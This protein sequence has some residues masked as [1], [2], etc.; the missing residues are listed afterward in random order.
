MAGLMAIDVY[1]NPPENVASALREDYDK[2]NTDW[3]RL[4][5]MGISMSGAS[6]PAKQVQAEKVAAPNLTRPE[7]APIVETDPSVV[8]D[9]S[10][11]FCR[12]YAPKK[13]EDAAGNPTCPPV[14]A[15][16]GSEM[17]GD[18]LRDLAV[19]L[20]VRTE[21][22]LRHRKVTGELDNGKSIARTHFFL[23]YD[24][25]VGWEDAVA[26]KAGKGPKI[27]TTPSKI[28]PGFFESIGNTIGDVKDWAEGV[29]ETIDD[30]FDVDFLPSDDA[31]P[32]D[33]Q[34]QIAAMGLGNS[35]T[36][37]Q[38]GGQ[39]KVPALGA[40]QRAFEYLTNSEI[41]ARYSAT[42]SL[43]YDE[44]GDWGANVTQAMG[45]VGAQYE[46][47]AAAVDSA[48]ST[49]EQRGNRLNITGHSLGGGLAQAAAMYC[50]KTYPHIRLK[51]VHFN[52]AGLHETTA[53]DVSGALLSDAQNFP[54]FAQNVAGELLT[55]VQTPGTFPLV[56]NIFNW[57]GQKIP[58]ALGISDKRRAI[59]PGPF[60]VGADHTHNFMAPEPP[61]P[62]ARY[63]AADVPDGDLLPLILPIDSQ[64]RFTSPNFEYVYEPFSPP[65]VGG[66]TGSGA[67]PLQTPLLPRG[68]ENSSLDEISDVGALSN[69]NTDVL[70]PP[71]A[72]MRYLR[73]TE[74]IPEKF[75]H[76][77]AILGLADASADFDSFVGQL[78]SYL[79]QQAG[80]RID[81]EYEDASA[82]AR[83]S[84][85]AMLTKIV[86]ALKDLSDDIADEAMKSLELIMLCL[87]Y[88]PMDIGGSTFL[89]PPED[90]S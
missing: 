47:V 62:N 29:V 40:A 65:D 76:I 31:L 4:W 55:S 23:P 54:M 15:F 12:F 2:I 60:P 63:T 24:L 52:A 38:S 50:H 82:L 61:Y 27:E 41:W 51:C 7:G 21:F 44:G 35:Q 79:I 5:E 37:L 33:I 28:K 14:L 88:H 18:E 66:Y 39:S 57:Q 43:F 75:Q 6:P 83:L 48:I 45:S 25:D 53:K 16:R 22:V 84:N 13:A 81:K 69:G 49:A 85:V 46:E 87:S 30:H 80:E 34:E 68:L 77:S 59:S 70:L 89:R 72:G 19:T 26:G 3:D 56:W 11:M 67:R 73:P 58:P 1:N 32:A 86:G 36:V 10:G 74:P 64:N 71:A 20:T 78:V 9:G 17:Q 8:Q 42:A 90:E